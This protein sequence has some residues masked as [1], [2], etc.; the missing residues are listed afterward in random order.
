MDGNE[1]MR[2]RLGGRPLPILCYHR[3]LPNPP[4]GSRLRIYITRAALDRQLRQLARRRMT[5]ISFADLLAARPLPKRPVILTFDD[6]YRDNYEH[7]LPLLEKHD[8]RATVFA[9]GDRSLATNRWDCEPGEP[10]AA[11]LMSDEELAACAASGHIEIGSHGLAHRHLKQLDDAELVHELAASKAALEA[12]TGT[13]VV[14]FAYPWGEYGP[15]ERDA[16][17]RAGYAFGIATDRG[18][19]ILTDRY[20]AARRIMFPST[21]AFGFYKKTSAW[22]PHYR[23]LLGRPA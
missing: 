19:P 2:R 1:A 16:V 8:A 12:V 11:A 14:S 22:Y 4:A 10:E 9:L 5:T 17:A 15:R 13:P 3:V 21:G 6:G 20:A 18:Q 23:H 7:L